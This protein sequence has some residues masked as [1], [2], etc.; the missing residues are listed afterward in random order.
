MYNA[1]YDV[2]REAI[3]V[4][5]RSWGGEGLLGC[6]VGYG[7]LHRIP[8]PQDRA[9]RPPEDDDDDDD[10]E[11]E[12]SAPT[13]TREFIDHRASQQRAYEEDLRSDG[14]GGYDSRDSRTSS[15]FSAPPK[16]GRPRETMRRSD[17][18]DEVPYVH[19]QVMGEFAASDGVEVVPVQEDEEQDLSG[20]VS[21]DSFAAS[22][23]V[24]NVPRSSAATYASPPPL[25]RH[26]PPTMGYG[27]RRAGEYSDEDS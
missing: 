8:K 21:A 14:R 15:I 12:Q 18:Y 5:N 17:G 13:Q 27:G 6:G 10:Q 4:P 19:Q 25:T 23:G 2:T 11:E 24:M 3:L 9:A 1:D 20:F 7:L 26:L 16:N 22:A